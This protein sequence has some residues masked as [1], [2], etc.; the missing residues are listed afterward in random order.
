ML[1]AVDGTS[2]INVRERLWVAATA[3]HHHQVPGNSLTPAVPH[4]TG[5]V[6]MLT[7]FY[8]FH[9]CVWWFLQ[10]RLRISRNKQLRRAQFSRLCAT[11]VH[12]HASKYG[13]RSGLNANFYRSIFCQHL[14][15]CFTISKAS[16]SADFNQNP[17]LL[18]LCIYL[19][20]ATSLLFYLP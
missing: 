2:C 11:P 4:P 6:D 7:S 13:Y 5:R 19:P 18:P 14:Q 8:H 15:T 9:C 1:T 17:P 20:Q 12:V 10:Q 16:N 3:K